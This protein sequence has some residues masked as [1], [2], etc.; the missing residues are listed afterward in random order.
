MVFLIDAGARGSL[1]V[2]ARIEREIV[3]VARVLLQNDPSARRQFTNSEWRALVRK[4]LGPPLA[5][6][7]L[8][9]DPLENAVEI[10]TSVRVAIEE[11]R[12]KH[13][14]RQ[15]AVECTLF[16][17]TDIKPIVMGPV[18]IESRE[19]WLTRM[20]S[21]GAVTAITAR[22][23]RSV[24]AGAA[25]SKKRKAYIDQAREA[26][27]LEVVGKCTFVC[28][29]ATEGLPPETGKAKALM[30]GRMALSAISLA[31]NKPSA[32]LD[33]FR[34]KV[35]GDVRLMR[36]L[37]YAP[38]KITLAGSTLSHMPS[39][40]TFKPG[41][42]EIL[43]APLADHFKITGEILAFFTHATGK[44][45][46]SELMN[47]LMQALLWFHEAC[48]ETVDAMAVV[49]FTSTLDALARANEEDGIRQL[50]TARIGW[51]DDEQIYKRGGVTMKQ[52]VKQVYRDG[53]S[54]TVHGTNDNLA[55]DWTD[56]RSLAETL[57]R[58]ALVGCMD[59]AARYPNES[60]PDQL[61]VKAATKSKTRS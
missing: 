19:D 38:R 22:R 23:V 5:N 36:V 32:V 46:R 12:Q 3:D 1:Y 2:N 28:S 17:N 39:G 45:K 52:A 15:Y 30:A 57:A 16:G 33:G 20:V 47:T 50:L 25:K 48:R 43:A 58:F 10:L 27:I 61:R 18:R 14:P 55:N 59:W 56:M 11:A 8:D 44:V 37:S 6:V 7:D 35:D 31:W 9:D 34:L 53:R 60:D 21:E 13:G 42:W 49:K 26:D 4:A 41:E 29:I 40:Y 24:W 51:K 54:R